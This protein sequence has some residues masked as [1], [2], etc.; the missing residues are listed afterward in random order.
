MTD[1]TVA[2]SDRSKDD[3]NL[4]SNIMKIFNNEINDVSAGAHRTV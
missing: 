2:E 4:T 1:Y 3:R